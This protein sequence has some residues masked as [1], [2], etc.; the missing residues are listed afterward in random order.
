MKE[1]LVAT[2]RKNNYIVLET[3]SRVIWPDIF[4]N[5]KNPKGTRVTRDFMSEVKRAADELCTLPN[6]PVGK[7]DTTD[8]QN[9]F[10][11]EDV[12]YSVE[13]MTEQMNEHDTLTIA[14]VIGLSL[15]DETQEFSANQYDQT[16]IIESVLRYQGAYEWFCK[17]NHQK[18]IIFNSLCN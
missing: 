4:V 1:Q 2:I 7:L 18:I 12:Y 5:V 16:N 14:G 10:L 9:F 11:N 13:W 3:L 6:A 15:Y 8:A 17:R